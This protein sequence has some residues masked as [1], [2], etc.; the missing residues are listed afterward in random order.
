MDPSEFN[1]LLESE[2][3]RV[4]DVLGSK[5]TEY[6]NGKDVLRNFKQAAALTGETVEQALAG[7]MAKHTVSIYD[8]VATGEHYTLE[9]WSEKITD[10]I[11]YL[12]LLKAILVE[13]HQNWVDQVK[14][15]VPAAPSMFSGGVQYIDDPSVVLL[16]RAPRFRARSLPDHMRT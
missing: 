15:E 10:H 5:Q 9:Q 16:N 4:T 8:M 13:R 12:I 1:L 6:A 14:T 2:L 11:N 3:S 7:M